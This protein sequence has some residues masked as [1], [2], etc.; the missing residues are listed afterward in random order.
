MAGQEGLPK[1]THEKK[2][3]RQTWGKQEAVQKRGWQEGT[4]NPRRA[5]GGIG[6]CV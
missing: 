1:R 5:W 4:R 2:V 3:D 6:R